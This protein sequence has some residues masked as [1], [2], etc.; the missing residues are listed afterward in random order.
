MEKIRIAVGLSGSGT[1]FED[2]ITACK[3]GK[4]DGQVVLVFSDKINCRGLERAHNHK[5]PCILR[6]H[7]WKEWR[8]GTFLLQILQ[9]MN[10]NLICLAGFLKLFPSLIVEIY[11][12]RIFNSHPALDIQR[13]GGKGMYGD[14][15]TEAVL[16]AGLKITGSTIHIVDEIYDHGPIV[17]QNEI[18]V[19]STDTPESLL[20]RQLGPEREMYV[21]AIQLFQQGRL[22]V[23]GNQ[24]EI[25][26]ER[27]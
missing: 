26:P 4:I 27:G 2:I 5:I 15:V 17:L 16:K 12:N 8:D 19:L 10:V 24:V 7:P 23:S 25:L 1:T 14:H 9:A 20:A 11:K 3:Q 13:F 22:K 6:C 21:R 18:K